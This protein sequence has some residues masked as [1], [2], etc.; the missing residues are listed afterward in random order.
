M[1]DEPVLKVILTI[2]SS[3]CLAVI[4]IVLGGVIGFF[5]LYYYCL[6]M[7]NDYMQVG[8][9]LAYITVPVGMLA[10]GG[11]G[12]SLPVLFWLMWD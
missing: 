11:L 3:L 5:G 1:S 10:G 8:W 6:F 9:A 12:F 2:I 4:G 7:G